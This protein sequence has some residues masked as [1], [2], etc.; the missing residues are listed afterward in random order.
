M[1]YYQRL[2]MAVN[3]NLIEGVAYTAAELA[4]KMAKVTAR[5]DTYGDAAAPI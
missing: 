1:T 2:V 4:A 3:Q 5:G